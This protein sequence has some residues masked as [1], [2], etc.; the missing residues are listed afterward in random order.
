MFIYRILVLAMVMFGSLAQVELVWNLAD[1]FMG[2][3]AIINITIILLLG[4]IAF[5]VLDDFTM[6]RNAGKNPVFYA[7]SIPKLKNTDCW[8]E[9][10]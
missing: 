5:Q 1:L 8:E 9:D 3:M 6:Q 2:L 4:K 10:R 7:K